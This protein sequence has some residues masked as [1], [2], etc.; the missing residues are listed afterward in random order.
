MPIALKYCETFCDK[1]FKCLKSK[2]SSVSK[3][4]SMSDTEITKTVVMVLIHE[5]AWSIL[6]L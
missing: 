1:S 5:K 2:Q 3:L 4:P 6:R